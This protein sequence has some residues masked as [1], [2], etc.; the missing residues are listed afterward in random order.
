MDRIKINDNGS[1]LNNFIIVIVLFLLLGLAVFGLFHNS[2]SSKTKSHCLE[3]IF[4]I[5][6]ALS[7]FFSSL[8]SNKEYVSELI[9]F[10]YEI[11]L[12]YKIKNKITQKVRIEKTKIKKFIVDTYV[13]YVKVG[14]GSGIESKSEF[15]I[16]LTDN[17][18]ITFSQ[19]TPFNPF[20]CPYEILFNLIKYSSKIPN[21]DIKTHTTNELIKAEIDYYRRFGKRLP[22]FVKTKLQLKSMPLISKIM[23]STALLMFL[24]SLSLFILII[25]LPEAKLNIN[26]K[27]YI[28]N[29]SKAI[30]YRT[31]DDNTFA[32]I[33]ALNEAE[34]YIDNDVVLYIEYAYNYKDLKDYDRAILY[35]KKGLTY[36]KNKSVYDK[37]HRKYMFNVSSHNIALYDVLL[38]CYK[39]KKDYVNMIFCANYLI[40]NNH[41]K[42]K[43]AYF[44]RGQAYY[45]LGQFDKAEN[46]FLKHKEIILEYLEEQNNSEYKSDYPTYTQKDY[47]RILRWLKACSELKNK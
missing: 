24:F 37:A 31:S 43:D 26:E 14:R 41:Y 34:K 47:N 28:N 15:S 9:I 5:I 16:L 35:A 4:V 45:H 25:P 13:N 30:E 21:I 1:F 12:I 39:K 38:R 11:E 44:Q 33:S 23:L 6:T 20:I 19:N 36:L 27:K 17:K 10:N 3:A 29:L 42:Y 8:S 2:T 22:F 32:A 40:E 7:I 46:D 18:E